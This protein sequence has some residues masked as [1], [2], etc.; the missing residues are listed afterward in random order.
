[1]IFCRAEVSLVRNCLDQFRVASGLSA[2][3]NKSSMF[4]CG[5]DP[6]TELHFLYALGCREGKLS[7]R[8]LGVPLITTKLCSHDCLI[9][10]DR[11]MAKAR[12]SM[13]RTLS[14]AG[15]LQLLNS[16]FSFYFF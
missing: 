12:S 8:Y 15:R 2:N 13:N 1:V 11:I 5:V 9:L 14:H 6:N 10:V 3:L 7:V 4:L 16:I